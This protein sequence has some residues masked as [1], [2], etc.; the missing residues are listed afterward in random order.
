VHEFKAPAASF[1]SKRR[2]TFGSALSPPGG[3]GNAGTHRSSPPV[4]F[5]GLRV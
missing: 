2:H 1:E 4:R 3:T 5:S